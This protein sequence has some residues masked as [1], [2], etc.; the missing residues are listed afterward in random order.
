MVKEEDLGIIKTI[1]ELLE[2]EEKSLEN[3]ML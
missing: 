2:I 3:M 1:S